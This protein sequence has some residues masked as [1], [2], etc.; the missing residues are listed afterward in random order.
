MAEHR[1]PG[2]S[3][4]STHR[5]KFESNYEQ[6]IEEVPNNFFRTEE[7][8]SCLL[9]IYLILKEFLSVMQFIF[10]VVLLFIFLG[11]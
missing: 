10:F 1:L 4:L 3:L 8:C 11:L 5:N 2:L 6:F 7:G 9:F